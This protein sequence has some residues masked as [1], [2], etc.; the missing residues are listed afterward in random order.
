MIIKLSERVLRYSSDCYGIRVIIKV[1][2]W[3][4][5]VWD[6]HLDG[7]EEAEGEGEDDQ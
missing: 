7:D 3:I 4:L 6:D 5:L 2:E 1:S